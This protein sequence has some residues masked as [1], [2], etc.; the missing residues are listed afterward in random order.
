M[1]ARFY[2]GILLRIRVTQGFCSSASPRLPSAFSFYLPYAIRNATILKKVQTS[3]Y[4]K[5]RM[6]FLQEI[7]EFV[8][9]HPWILAITIPGLAYLLYW[10]WTKVHPT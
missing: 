5:R 1:A 4:P 8:W 2:E 6:V 10:I 7:R 9:E 3:N